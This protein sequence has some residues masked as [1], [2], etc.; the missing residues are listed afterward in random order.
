MTRAER[1]RA[2]ALLA[3]G[4]ELLFGGQVDLNSS[5][6]ARRLL[7]VGF[8]P[9]RF[10]V[11]GDD[12]DELVRQLADLA[13][14]HCAIIVT[15]GLGPTLD[16]VTRH[17][18]ARAAGVDLESNAQVLRDLKALFE[19][20]GR[21]FAR[22]N[23]RQALFPSGSEVLPNPH[24]T[25]AGFCVE[26]A[27]ALVFAL[28]GPPREMTPMLE[29]YVLPRL[30]SLSGAGAAHERR[31]F[32]LLGLSESVFADM[33]GTW[34]GR[35]MNPLVG[36]TAVHGVLSV[37]LRARAR[38][39]DEACALVDARG[40]E[41]RERFGEWI[42]SETQPEPAFALGEE[43][44]RRGTRVSIAESC[45]GGLVAAKLTRVPGISAVFERG[46]VTYSNEAK[47]ELLGVDPEI[48]RAHGAVSKA[49]AIAMAR[50]AAERA[51][52]SAAVSVTG[53]AGPS[54]GSPEKPVGL[55]WFGVYAAGIVSSAERHFVV[56][57]RDLIREFA[58]NTALDLLRR[59]LTH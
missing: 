48:L 24:G 55:V 34:M 7:D 9:R 4:D 37:T 44:L 2:V 30:A 20:R 1:E 56:R 33:C 51:R 15:G 11:L 8:E 26:V 57:D 50:G 23:E 3:T 10:V 16:D 13:P 25:A 45:T 53:I 58:A 36:V 46:F 19:S 47:T 17:A 59:A 28:P 39:R 6:I 22:A 41:V 12:E 40:A 18:C 29:A 21:P 31:T 5:A 43:L 38:T 32:Y 27:G 49:V 42:F 52:A 14:A 54:G 35:A